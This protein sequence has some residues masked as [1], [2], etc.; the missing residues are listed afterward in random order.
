M[1]KKMTPSIVGNWK[2]TPKTLDEGLKFIKQ[3]EKKLSKTKIKLPKKSYYLAVPE[4]FIAPLS[5][6]ALC[7]H[8]GA[9]TLH[10]T[11]LGQ[12]T[13][14]TTPEQLKSAGASFILVGHSEVRKKGETQEERKEKVLKAL[15]SKLTTILC[16]GELTRD[17]NGKYLEALE[18]DVKE[19]LQDVPRER[20][21]Y[22]M[23]AYEPIWA[24]GASVPATANE[25]FEAVIALRRA[26]ASLAGIDYAKK[27]QI[28]YGG[29]VKDD[30][31]K[32]FIEEGGV[33]GLL[34]GRSSQELSS[35]LSIIEDVHRNN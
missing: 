20:F 29:T 22:L 33:D 2:A 9:Q 5:E 16:V 13:G 26:L 18:N 12:T 32:V 7:G 8:I 35:F 31:A 24:I 30:N 25:C 34:I 6:E 21:S 14:G 28:L 17:K 10:G 1:A 15:T 19:I 3:L 23:I 4:V 27:V 11:T